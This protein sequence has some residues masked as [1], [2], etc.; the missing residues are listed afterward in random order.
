MDGKH[1]P[2][3][4]V[5]VD[6]SGARLYRMDRMLKE[7][8][9]AA[10]AEIERIHHEQKR[11]IL[12]VTVDSI[13]TLLVVS[14]PGGAAGHTEH[15]AMKY[16]LQNDMLK[17]GAWMLLMGVHG[18]CTFHS[19][20]CGKCRDVMAL[21]AKELNVEIIY[22]TSALL[23]SIDESEEQ[24]KRAQRTM[25]HFENGKGAWRRKKNDFYVPKVGTPELAEFEVLIERAKSVGAP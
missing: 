2:H 12:Q 19:S 11:H 9:D 17:P 7:E 1:N 22:D 16:L 6:G 25:M 21:I 4:I 8:L 13:D 14:G 5:S 20:R 10:W 3:Y 23:L 18:P 15:A 24:M